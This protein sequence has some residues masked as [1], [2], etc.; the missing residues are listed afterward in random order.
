MMLW[1]AGYAFLRPL[2]DDGI[3]L[4]WAV[5]DTRRTAAVMGVQALFALVAV[6]VAIL[7]G[8]VEGLAYCMGIVA[9]IGVFGVFVVLRRYV[10]IAWRRVFVAPMAALALATLAGAVFSRII[11]LSQWYDLVA[12]SGILLVVYGSVLWLLERQEVIAQWERLRRILD[13]EEET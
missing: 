11:E 4:L 13:E 8:G 1:L 3:G 12:R 5:G 6:P 2:F 10:D 7:W 9:A